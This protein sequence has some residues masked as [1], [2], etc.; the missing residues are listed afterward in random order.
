MVLNFQEKFHSGAPPDFYD[1]ISI[2]FDG[3]EETEV[4]APSAKRARA[5]LP[6]LL[7]ES[8]R[9]QIPA[10]RADG[11]RAQRG[12]G[13]GRGGRGG[14]SRQ[15]FS[16]RKRG[17][18]RSPSPAVI[19]PQRNH[20]GG[21]GATTS[22]AN[23]LFASQQDMKDTQVLLNSRLMRS[24]DWLASNAKPVQVKP[25]EDHLC[26]KELKRKL[27][28]AKEA[29][30]RLTDAQRHYAREASNPLCQVGF[31]VFSNRAGS[32]PAEL[33]YR[34]RE[35][36]I[37]NPKC[38]DSDNEALRWGNLCGAPG[39]FD[40]YFFTCHKT[41]CLGFGVSIRSGLAYDLERFNRSAP[42][43]TLHLIYGPD[44]SGDLVKPAT[45]YAFADEVKSKT[46]NRKLHVVLADGGID[47]SGQEDKQEIIS[48]P[49]LRAQLLTGLLT[50]KKGGN[51][52]CK[53]FGSYNVDTALTI[54]LARR[55]F[56]RVALEELAQ[57]R[58]TNSEMY[59]CAEDLKDEVQAAAEAKAYIDGRKV[60]PMLIDDDLLQYLKRVNQRK[61]ETQIHALELAMNFH[62]D[63]YLRTID[64]AYVAAQVHALWGLCQHR[65][66]T[67][68]NRSC[69]LRLD[70]Q[71]GRF[72]FGVESYFTG[73]SSQ[74]L[75]HNAVAQLKAAIVNDAEETPT[76]RMSFNS[77]RCQLYIL[78]GILPKEQPRFRGCLMRTPT[79]L[80]WSDEKGT[81]TPCV[82]EDL[83]L[84]LLAPDTMLDVL[85]CPP[86]PDSDGKTKVIVLDAWSLPWT[87]APR[88]CLDLQDVTS[89]T[90]RQKMIRVLIET[91]LQPQ[92][93][94]LPKRTT[95]LAKLA[96]LELEEDSNFEW[97]IFGLCETERRPNAS[98]FWDQTS[99]SLQSPDLA[100]L[101]QTLSFSSPYV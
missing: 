79:Q 38:W 70:P 66:K 83:P 30:G 21:G 6:P 93:I 9:Q 74:Q 39:G 4:I 22:S 53:T 23:I 10:F 82:W 101:V 72:H 31:R 80:C 13:R 19:R 91:R 15:T 62:T 58:P 28:V 35:S 26:D 40:E 8:R 52:V 51:F 63:R 75:F 29:F 56:H 48:L 42:T 85:V 59:L 33:D 27:N 44:D 88:P 87:G 64:P 41:R 100:T 96:E 46:S 25:T 77:N 81:I 65:E 2:M 36:L 78:E 86:I 24:M 7:P 84:D 71:W 5:A 1:S 50:L 18:S 68:C 76:L 49:L 99:Q 67:E 89:W 12:G 54:Q 57:S 16:S 20:G 55:H 61:A 32:K 43:D 11:S 98:F 69:R 3:E 94:A 60:W 73:I 45:I 95:T 90:T 47:F 34:S 92:L 14:P 97:G 17:R 37:R